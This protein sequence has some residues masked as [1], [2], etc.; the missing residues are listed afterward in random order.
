MPG[1]FSPLYMLMSEIGTFTDCALITDDTDR[2]Y[3]TGMKSSAGT[4]V[5]FSSAAYLI[6]DSRYIEK[7]EPGSC[8]Y[9]PL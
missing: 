7:Q 1:E 8:F 5:V 9:I 6:I 2:R 3:F 4:L